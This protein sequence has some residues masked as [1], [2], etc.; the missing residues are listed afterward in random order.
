MEELATR[1]PDQ[2]S[3]K[4]RFLNQAAR[5]VLLAMS[6]DWPFI[7][8]CRTSVEYAKKR[9]EGHLKN[10]NLVYDD[11]CKNAVDTEWLVKAEKRHTIF[12]DIDYN[13]F[14][15]ERI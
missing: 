3:L 15:S 1:F 5:E 8:Y 12:G 10:V 7:I 6:S 4:Q 11:M 2:T 13:I 9:I 14:N